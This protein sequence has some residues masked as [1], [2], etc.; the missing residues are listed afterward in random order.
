MNE[1]LDIGRWAL[2]PQA[3][4]P[5]RP[6]DSVRDLRVATFVCLP[7]ET[8]SLKSHQF[9]SSICKPT[10]ACL[11]LNPWRSRRGYI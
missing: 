6:S 9:F 4:D 7:V 2:R 8:K 3:E 5:S 11:C 1:E 10:A